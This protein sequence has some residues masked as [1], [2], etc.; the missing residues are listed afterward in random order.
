MVD[1]SKIAKGTAVTFFV[2][3]IGLGLN[4]VF[5]I[6]LARWLGPESFGMYS[7]GLSVFN[8]LGLLALL[9]LDN[10]VLRYVPSLAFNNIRNV[11]LNII[12]IGSVSCI[13]VTG[14]A[15][16]SYSWLIQKTGANPDLLKV[17][18]YFFMAIPA[19]VLGAMLLSVLQARHSVQ[20]RMLAKYVIEP[21]T[22]FAVVISLMYFSYTLTAALVGF[23]VASWSA[24]L[25]AGWGV[26]KLMDKKQQS[27]KQNGSQ[28]KQAIIR[29]SLPLVGS[30]MLSGI[31]NRSD[32]LLLTQ[33]QTTT[34]VG[35]YSAAMQTAAM[36]VI[37]GGC[38][39]SV[40]S[41]YLSACVVKAE[42]AELKQLY[43]MSLRW[44]FLLGLPLFMMF[45]IF[46][47]EIMK[48]FGHQFAQ[49]GDC[50]R[51]LAVAQMINL[52]T[53]SANPILLFSGRTKIVLINSVVEGVIQ[54]V[55][56]LLLIPKYG[57][58]GAALGAAIT[59]GIINVIRVFEVYII[60]GLHPYRLG[61]VKPVVV[62]G[63]FAIII[64]IIQ[65]LMFLDIDGFLIGLVFALL[66]LS[67]LCVGMEKEDRILLKGY[68]LRMK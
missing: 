54:L 35:L 31:G 58:I 30:L 38:I 1:V 6:F 55:F 52:A 22:K 47:T 4:Y 45:E 65:S 27:T 21:V 8:L 11:V 15:Y 40:F 20:L 37:V 9:G 16:L 23:V 66:V 51:I 3:F 53:G 5:N 12:G 67:I 18:P 59:M 68:V 57:V 63:L 42:I 7:A 39:E 34:D 46:E 26:A 61:L 14:V 48:I 43:A 19:Y 10:A 44:M 49:V 56:N 50:L 25:V 62:A 60:Y 28:T 64:H 2:M 24:A 29:Y 32:I 13:V 41:P 33:F 36:L 17:L